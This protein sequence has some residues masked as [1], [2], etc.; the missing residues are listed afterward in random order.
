MMGS[1]SEQVTRMIISHFEIQELLGR[2]GQGE[3]YRA[4]DRRLGRI[5]ALKLFHRRD[6]TEA[7]PDGLQ[8]EARRQ[9]ALNHPNLPTVYE[10]GLWENRC[11]LAMEYVKG[12][13]LARRLAAGP[14]EIPAAVSIA[15][16]VAGALQAIHAAGLI[17]GDLSSANIMMLPGGGVKMLDLGMAE[18]LPKSALAGDPL[19]EP[20]GAVRR[21]PPDRAAPGATKAVLSGTIPYL[22]PEALRG[23]RRDQRS[24]VFALGGLLYEMVTGRHPFRRKDAAATLAA[25]MEEEPPPLSRAQHRAPLELER[26]VRR[27]LAKQPTERYPTAAD[28]YGDLQALSRRLESESICPRTSSEPPSFQPN[29]VDPRP[30]PRAWIRLQMFLHRQRRSLSITGSIAAATAVFAWIFGHPLGA[31]WLGVVLLLLV[32]GACLAGSVL[33]RHGPPPSFPQPV[34]ASAFQGLLP[35]VER[36]RDRFFGRQAETEALLTMVTGPELR[37]SVLVGESG[38]GKTSLLRAALLPRLWEA[39]YLPIYCRAYTDL[40]TA[41]GVEAQRQSQIARQPEESLKEYLCRLGQTLRTTLVIVCDQFEEFFVNFPGETEREPFLSFVTA[42][43]GDPTAPVKFLL[44]VR[45][46]FLHLINAEF[47]GR[48]PDPLA[49]RQL[50][51]LRNFSAAQAEEVIRRSAGQAGL[52][53]EPGFCSYLAR[54]LNAGKSVLPSELQIVGE[55][56]QNQQILTVAEYR[57]A[58]GKEQ[59]VNGFLADVI[60]LSGAPTKAAQVLHALISEENTRLTLPLEEIAGRALLGGETV[61]WMLQLFVQGR[62]V[63]EVRET[64]PCRYELVHE[65]LIEPIHRATGKVVDER[66]R[67]DRLLRQYLSNYQGD[68]QTRIPLGKLYFLLRFSHLARHGT[69]AELLRKSVWRAGWQVCLG[70][71]LALT[72]ALTLAAWLSVSETWGGVT[73]R[74]GHAAAALQA[75]FSPD[76]TRLVT[77]GEDGTVIVWD[78][79]HRRR[80][81]TFHDHSSGAWGLAFSP[82]GRFLATG[83]HDGIVIVREGVSLK[84]IAALPCDNWVNHLAFGPAKPLLVVIGK[85]AVSVWSTD[86]W[87]K[88]QEYPQGNGEYGNFCLTRTD[89]LVYSSKVLNIGDARLE[90]SQDLRSQANLQNWGDWNALSPDGTRLASIDWRGIVKCWAVGSTRCLLQKKAHHDHGRTVAFSPDGHWLASGAENIVLWDAATLT[91]VCRLDYPAIVWNVAFSRDSRWLVSTHGDG[92]VL[93]WDLQ[94]RALAARLDQ[95]SGP[96]RTVAFSADGRQVASAGDDQS[97]ILWDVTGAPRKSHT[98][99]GHVTRINGVAFSPDGSWLVSCDQMGRALRWDVARPGAPI[100][101][102]TMKSNSPLYN[103]AVIEDGRYIVTGGQILNSSTGRQVMDVESVIGASTHDYDYSWCAAAHLLAGAGPLSGPIA[104]LWEINTSS[105]R[106]LE[107]DIGPDAGWVCVSLAPDGQTLVTGND[108][109]EVW[110]WQSRP[111]RR[112]ALLGRH[113]ARVK[114]VVFSPDGRHVVS[115]G[116]DCTIKLW[117]VRNRRLATLIDTHTTPVL[118]LAFSPDGQRL[119]SG[120]YDHSVRLYTLHRTLWGFSLD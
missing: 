57:R 17:H 61:A 100:L 52:A 33:A 6:A 26:V 71:M 62:L 98:F 3:V 101:L 58:G 40:L 43:A 49:A 18:P 81:A 76:G 117:D 114:A 21:I 119:V 68:P 53:L 107:K 16:Q 82:D 1:D 66:Q 89:E 91:W 23:E 102:F 90:D 109:G 41:I 69:G 44:A 115:A 4:V 113:T 32:A 35:F 93:V 12:E 10:V 84:K 64:S 8:M 25:I 77:G 80:Q 46:D 79:L 85:H 20:E 65:Y 60:Q 97:I 39:G 70:S 116:D 30:S 78:F 55:Q 47:A 72:A 5:V 14:L 74:D 86:D 112:V 51:H 42:V 56:L 36:D 9:A 105:G 2:G 54:D 13:P 111:L 31:E 87:R 28:L 15:L 110:L 120:E 67:A 63:R 99:L 92:A 29:V 118:A 94:E 24:D 75:V 106:G 45:G 38:C 108:K 27:A 22:A 11:F 88:L 104:S 59:L 19:S 7:L 96:V 50:F 83:G 95:H 37:F 73:L 103:I 48:V 34:A